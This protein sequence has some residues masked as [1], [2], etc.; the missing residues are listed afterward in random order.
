MLSI[1][2]QNGNLNSEKVT[3]TL[4][5]PACG[6]PAAKAV[7]AE[8]TGSGFMTFYGKIACFPHTVSEILLSK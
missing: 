4:F 3:L 6:E 7:G 5:I 2:P 1:I 8:A